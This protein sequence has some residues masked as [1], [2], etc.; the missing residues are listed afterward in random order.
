MTC[1]DM[2]GGGMQPRWSVA[3]CPFSMPWTWLLAQERL[4]MN[5]LSLEATLHQ[6]SSAV[7][8]ASTETADRHFPD[9]TNNDAR[10]RCRRERHA[11]SQ[12][13]QTRACWPLSHGSRLAGLGPGDRRPPSSLLCLFPAQRPVGN[14]EEA[15]HTRDCL[16][17]GTHNPL[18]VLCGYEQGAS[19][20]GIR[21]F[22][23]PILTTVGRRRDRR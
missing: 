1:T 12:S 4:R 23:G 6:R 18:A 13:T 5:P 15:R 2:R 19:S 22:S 7:G 20:T 9:R 10:P 11:S 17:V 14:C 3:P 8:F 16:L 21:S